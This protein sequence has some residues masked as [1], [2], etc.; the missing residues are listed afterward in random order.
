MGSSA[1]WRNAT[2]TAG[3]GDLRAQASCV[4][5]CVAV[6][7]RRARSSIRRTYNP[8]P[9]TWMAGLTHLGVFELLLTPSVDVADITDGIRPVPSD[10]SASGP[11]F[12]K[13]GCR[14]GGRFVRHSIR[15]SE[16]PGTTETS[17]RNCQQ[18]FALKGSAEFNVG[19]RTRALWKKIECALWLLHLIPTFRQRFVQMIP[20][21]LVDG[22]IDQSRQTLPNDSLH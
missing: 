1:R 22:N 19:T 21:S 14:A 5:A 11:E 3:G 16:K 18:S 7:Q 8:L 9:V 17:A 15:Y 12:S 20:V 2:T 6:R 13:D 10:T 4:W